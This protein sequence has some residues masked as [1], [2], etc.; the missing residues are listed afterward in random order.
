MS[1]RCGG[2]LCFRVST[3]DH[4]ADRLTM[5]RL[6]MSRPACVLV[7]G[8]TYVVRRSETRPEAMH[9]H[10]CVGT[11]PSLALSVCVAPACDDTNSIAK[12]HGQSRTPGTPPRCVA[13]GGSLGLGF[14]G[15]GFIIG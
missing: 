5:S 3:A 13:S 11:L 6:T 12:A 9:D 10:F 14:W 7:Q 1:M 2:C 8:V 15:F 4:V